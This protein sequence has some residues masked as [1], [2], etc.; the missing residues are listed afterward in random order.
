MN[1]I[2][3]WTVWNDKKYLTTGPTDPPVPGELI[4]WDMFSKQGVYLIPQPKDVQ[5]DNE[6]T[7]NF[8]MNFSK[9]FLDC[10]LEYQ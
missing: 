3:I 2:V 1:G 8:K 7:L 5:V 4:K 10:S 9:L 6:I